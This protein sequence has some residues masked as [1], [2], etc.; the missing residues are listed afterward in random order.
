MPVPLRPHQPVANPWLLVNLLPA[1]ELVFL[2][3]GTGVGKSVLLAHWVS[4][5]STSPQRPADRKILYFSTP[6]QREERDHH[7]HTQQASLEG[8]VESIFDTSRFDCLTKYQIPFHFM[9]FI[10]EQLASQPA[11]C[12]IIDDPEELFTQ[13]G[14]VEPDMVEHF[15]MALR[16]LD[17]EHNTTIIV[18]RRHGL[19]ENRA[20]GLYTRSGTNHCRFILTL[21]YHQFDASKRVLMVAKHLHGPTGVQYHMAFE[22]AGMVTVREVEPHQYVKPCR[23]QQ[24]WQP[25]PTIERD[26]NEILEAA[27]TYMNGKAVPKQELMDHIVSLGYSKRS[28]RAVMS[29]AKLPELRNGKVWY[30]GP[31]MPWQIEDLPHART[32]ARELAA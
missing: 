21:Q 27:E 9:V 8:V 20:Y 16:Q 17:Y 31:R 6:L 13:A 19:N 15:W 28:F 23:T 14:A 7:L 11:H 3:G 30:F 12:V 2:D 26:D 32:A 18:P 4:D 22:S 5:F 1:N 29:R 25:D 10:Q 24:T